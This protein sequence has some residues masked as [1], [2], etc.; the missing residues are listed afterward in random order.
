MVEKTWRNGR[1]AIIWNIQLTRAL[2]VISCYTNF[3]M[4]VASLQAVTWNSPADPHLLEISSGSAVLGPF[5]ITAFWTISRF[6]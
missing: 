3:T 2:L 6:T 4:I 1:D 5:C